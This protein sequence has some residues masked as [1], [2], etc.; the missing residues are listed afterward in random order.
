M[1]SNIAC[2]WIKLNRVFS[3]SNEPIPVFF[4]LHSGFGTHLCWILIYVLLTTAFNYGIG[5]YLLCFCPNFLFYYLTSACVHVDVFVV[6]FFFLYFLKFGGKNRKLSQHNLKVLTKN[7]LGNVFSS[8]I[9]FYFHIT[10]N[11]ASF[12]LTSVKAK[13][14]FPAGA[15]P[16]L[17]C[18]QTAWP[19]GAVGCRVLNIL[20]LLV[21]RGPLSFSSLS[22]C[23]FK[24][25]KVY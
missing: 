15:V 7:V 21:Y 18:Q 4:R 11:V 19:V 9:P 8:E 12:S 2:L 10:S 16:A 23:L 24:K 25:K 6:V 1:C 17:V 14:N 20:R 13:V 5:K 3:F 22:K